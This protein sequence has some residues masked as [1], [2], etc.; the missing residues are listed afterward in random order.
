M[1]FS[2]IK[3][4]QIIARRSGGRGARRALFVESVSQ[5]SPVLWRASGRPVRI[6]DRAV[7]M[8]SKVEAFL[9]L[10]D[11]DTVEL[12]ED[13][14]E[15][16]SLAVGDMIRTVGGGF[17]LGT[18]AQVSMIYPAPRGY[19]RIGW[20]VEFWAP[21]PESGELRRVVLGLDDVER[22]DRPAQAVEVE[23]VDGPA[24]EVVDERTATVRA[25][26]DRAEARLRERGALPASP[27]PTFAP[28]VDQAAGEDVDDDQGPA[29]L[30]ELAGIT[31]EPAAAPA[32]APAPLRPTVAVR[33]SRL[34]ECLDRD[35]AD[36]LAMV[37]GRA[38]RDRSGWSV[39][40]AGAYRW[41]LD[42]SEARKVLVRLA[43]ALVARYAAG[44]LSLFD[45]AAKAG[46]LPPSA[47]YRA[48]RELDV[49]PVASP[50]PAPLVDNE[51]RARRRDSRTDLIKALDDI[52]ALDIESLYTQDTT[53]EEHE[54]RK[55][56]APMIKALTA[57]AE[58][59]YVYGY[60]LQTNTQR[61]LVA[62]GLLSP[63]HEVVTGESGG[64]TWGIRITDAGREAIA[65]APAV[66]VEVEAP[67]ALS[68]TWDRAL[69]NVAGSLKAEREA[70]AVEVEAP[71][72]E[73]DEQDEIAAELAEVEA[74]ADEIG[75]GLDEVERVAA[76]I[77]A[78]DETPA[79]A[80]DAD[81]CCVACGEHIAD[82]HADGCPEDLDA[83]D[84]A[85][86]QW[87][88]CGKSTP[89][90]PPRPAPAA[91]ESVVGLFEGLRDRAMWEAE[92]GRMRGAGVDVDDQVVDEVRGRLRG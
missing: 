91:V 83:V 71:A 24:V 17:P 76:E 48:G 67:A 31:V 86:G 75:A 85:G 59:G 32:P 49:R 37:V 10:V 77:R 12:I 42:K 44:R 2:D 63:E 65:P 16:G 18:V 33:S 43:G 90:Y 52:K 81:D 57:A 20:S 51:G 30:F 39:R 15:I 19:G 45:Y 40:V 74:A 26:L 50:A 66:E 88:R 11:S 73:V 47:A 14:Q 61:A 22:A 68:S 78:A 64:L 89:C 46:V 72:V 34:V 21:C 38:E 84:C 60:E 29:D 4:G 53:Q 5:V 55:L 62:A 79:G 58:R 80:Y 25:Q 87:C 9:L 23:V 41:G 82:P 7:H 36:E 56:T 3:V 69:R 28:L 6:S 92:W 1:E 70:A 13:V 54:M 35:P 27:A 8:F